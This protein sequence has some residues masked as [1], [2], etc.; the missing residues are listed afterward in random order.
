[1]DAYNQRDTTGH[2]MAV[3]G[4]DYEFVNEDG[5]RDSYGETRSYFD[6]RAFRGNTRHTIESLFVNSVDE[7]TQGASDSEWVAEITETILN[8]SINGSKNRRTIH[9]TDTWHRNSS[10]AWL[11]R[12]TKNVRRERLVQ[13]GSEETPSTSTRH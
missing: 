10:G 8:E 7:V 11:W 3:Y 9:E 1:M 4:N 5:R 2:I 13:V 12:S 6:S